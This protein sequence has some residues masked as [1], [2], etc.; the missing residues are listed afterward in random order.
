MG[1]KGKWFY[2]DKDEIIKEV[3]TLA[4]E[5]SIKFL[6]FVG[7]W[8]KGRTKLKLSC[9]THG[10]W[11]TTTLSNF[12]SLGYGCAL[13]KR[14]DATFKSRMSDD[15]IK[16]SFHEKGEFLNLTFER[17]LTRKTKHNTYP[18]IKI[19]CSVCEKDE[20]SKAGVG[21]EFFFST[22]TNLRAGKHPCRCSVSYRWTESELMY[23]IN[24]VAQLKGFTVSY[25][26]RDS[27]DKLTKSCRVGFS[28]SHGHELEVP[29]IKFLDKKR[30]CDSCRKQ[31]CLYYGF[32]EDRLD[33]EDYLYVIEFEKYLKIGRSFNPKA[34]VTDLIN[35]SEDDHIQ[36]EI[37]KGIHKDVYRIEQDILQSF[38]KIFV[39]WT[40][41]TVEKKNHHNILRYIEKE[42]L[43]K[44][45]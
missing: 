13:C 4:K 16:T 29:I 6:G 28:C 32:Y 38:R 23:D 43:I 2:E 41:E 35:K 7:E 20:Y 18:Y 33:R 17:D 24:K 25:L 45:Q 14:E 5:R 39:D 19:H 37:F 34:R 42:N 8:L 9:D 21:R 31:H 1:R 11:D 27:K 30:G 44:H 26:V 3:E 12:V 10:E 40:T 15:E 36:V 22:L